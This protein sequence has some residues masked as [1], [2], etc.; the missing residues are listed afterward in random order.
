MI[1]ELRTSYGSDTLMRQLLQDIN[2]G[3]DKVKHYSLQNG[4]LL[5]KGRTYLGPTCNLKSKVAHSQQS[6]R[7]TFWVLEVI[8]QAE[9]GFLL[10][11]HEC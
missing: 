10:G 11:R 5:Y 6:H 9:T 3:K 2:Q 8:S 7:W 4:L 1:E